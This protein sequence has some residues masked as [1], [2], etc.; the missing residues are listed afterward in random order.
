MTL[1]VVMIGPEPRIYGGISAVAGMLLDSELP[2]RV[3]LTY[4]VEGT[5]RSRAAKLALALLAP[6]RLAARL[7]RR[8][9]D[10][11][12]LHVGDGGSFYRH[13]LYL[14][15]CHLAG[16]P[17]V[18]HW[19]LPGNGEAADAGLNNERQRRLARWALQHSARVIVLSPAWAATLTRLAADP[20]AAT[21]MVALPNPVDCATIYPGAAPAAA[22]HTV[23]FLGDFSA[24]KGVRELL[25]AAPAVLSAHPATRFVI[26]GGDPPA[27]VQALAAPLATA[28][29]FPGFVRGA[30]KLHA[31][32]QA[33]LLVLPSYAEGMPVAVLEA[34]AAGLPVVTTPVGG[35]PDFFVDG[36]NGLL[37]PP[38][39]AA[40][41]AA[42][43]NRLL[44]DPTLCAEMAR[45]NRA[46]ALAH[47]DTPPYM[48]RVLG[49]Y[50]AISR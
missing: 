30:A 18:L 37:T 46:Q 15:L 44:A 42:A 25:A 23:L 47:F 8:Q 3:H 1:R 11:C 40:A 21:R 38:G 22:R 39:D 36:V 14:A 31:L 2:R 50:Q 7:L 16:A 43:L 33:A 5:R 10:V 19:H 17:V 27:E 12:H 35:I 32:Q 28:V 20:Q 6:L 24:R 26:A 9:V 45:H 4:I 49:V 13:V 29:E 34:L 41:L 48:E